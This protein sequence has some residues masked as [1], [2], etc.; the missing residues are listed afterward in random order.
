[1]KSLSKTKTVLLLTFLVLIWGI[2]WPLSKY[3]LNFTP[4]ILFAGMR[5]LLGGILLFF[6]AVP[7]IKSLKFKQNWAAYVI[8]AFL[9]IIVFYGLQ[10]VGLGFMPAGLFSAIVFLQPVL[11]GI[12]SWLWLG[13]AM[14]GV[15]IIGL[16]LGFLGVGVIS[17]NGILGHLSVIGILLALG[18]SLGWA[19]GTVY[20]KKQGARVDAIWMVT[21]QLLIGGVLLTGLGLG[22][23]KWSS[24][25]WN[26]PYITL[27]LF[28]SIFVIALGWLDFF[29]LVGAGE[30]SIVGSYTFIIPLVS[31]ITSALF[32]HESITI[33]LI[34]GLVLVV[35]SI[36]FVS[37][38]PKALRKA[39]PGPKTSV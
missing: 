16:I 4:P 13:E 34:A 26:T 10:T 12:F 14:Y 38:K 3:A 11:L 30:A 8:S 2:N 25:N 19:F 23:E 27:L 6:Y 29:T 18:T 36:L 37:I 28:I 9:N 39:G 21:F 17:L 24:I 5:T 20:V 22:T 15:K 1:M 33:N 35:I 31:V 32:F 7:R